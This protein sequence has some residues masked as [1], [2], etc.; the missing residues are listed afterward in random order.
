MNIF[1]KGILWVSWLALLLWG[2]PGLYK[3]FAEGRD[4]SNC[5][6]YVPWGLWVS[7]YIYFVGLSAGAFLFSSLVYV[8]RIEKLAKIGRTALWLA[9]VTLLIALAC[10]WCDLG[11]KWRFWEVF[12]R[13]QFT[14]MMAWMIWLYTAYFVLI[15]V[16]LWLVLRCDMSRLGGGGGLMAPVYR[17]LCL[18]NRCPEGPQEFEACHRTS[19]RALRILGGLGV[20]LATILGGGAGSLLATLAA[21]PFWHHPILPVL[22]LTGALVSGGGLLLA[23][24]ALTHRGPEDERRSLLKTLSYTVVGLLVF[25]LLLESAEFSIPL[26]NAAGQEGTPLRFVLFGE[27][28]YVFWI[29]HLLAGSIFPLVLLV[30][31]PGARLAAGLGGGLVAITFLAVRLNIVIPG[32]IVPALAGLEEAYVDR[33]LNFDYVPS[34]FEWSVVAFLAAAGIALFYLGAWLLPLSEAEPETN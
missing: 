15:L 32:Q 2:L 22:F 21:R 20:P 34:G 4:L 1:T 25:Y 17:F 10:I 19:L 6:S 18:G 11:Q 13:P 14:S 9:A 23:I 31:K 29:I 27:F 30:W 8:F 3:L 5:G 7:A 16:E 33:R 12:T 24:V 28:W 26:W